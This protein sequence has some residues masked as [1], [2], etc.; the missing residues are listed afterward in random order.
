MTRRHRRQAI[1][2]SVFS[3]ICFF[4]VLI[5]ALGAVDRIAG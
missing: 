2:G 5:G 3:F 1:Y 4:T